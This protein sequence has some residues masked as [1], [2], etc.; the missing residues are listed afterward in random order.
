MKGFSVVVL[1]IVG[2]EERGEE[3]VHCG[4]GVGRD[5]VGGDVARD[6]GLGV[7]ARMDRDLDGLG[8]RDHIGFRG[9]GGPL[10][11]GGRGHEEGRFCGLGG[12]DGCHFR[13]L[14]T[15]RS[16]FEMDGRRFRCRGG[17]CSDGGLLTGELGHVG[18]FLED[19]LIVNEV[20]DEADEGQKE[21]DGRNEERQGIGEPALGLTEHIET[22]DGGDDGEVVVDEREDRHEGRELPRD[23]RDADD[24]GIDDEDHRGADLNEE[25]QRA[26]QERHDGCQTVGRQ[27]RVDALNVCENAGTEDQLRKEK[28]DE[29]DRF[30]AAGNRFPDHFDS[31]L[32]SD[33]FILCQH[34]HTSRFPLDCKGVRLPYSPAET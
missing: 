34:F 6:H 14:D 27:E 23:L 33:N 10:L 24:H 19:A 11:F 21:R 12:L 28:E 25:E 20:V 29:D 17:M 2:T 16:L 5:V 13:L 4:D 3:V 18:R 22:E 8:G 1:D 15:D 26:G 9:L 31:L 7:V 32:T 30:P